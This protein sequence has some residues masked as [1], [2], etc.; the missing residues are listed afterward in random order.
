[1]GHGPLKTFWRVSLPLAAPGLAAG[2][3]LMFARAIG[4]FGATTVLAGNLEGETRTI[5]LA[6]YTLLESPAGGESIRVL[7]G[8]SIALS[9]LAM[10]GYERLS[11]WQRHRAEV[12]DD[13]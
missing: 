12:H 4:E 7:V 10:L 13:G 5:A 2:A 11:R 8:A 3:V 6:V 1:M 9:F